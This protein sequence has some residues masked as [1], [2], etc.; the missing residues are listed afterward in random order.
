MKPLG[1]HGALIPP[2]R[3]SLPHR[4]CWVVRG[5]STA[6][7]GGRAGGAD[8]GPSDDMNLPLRDSLHFVPVGPR[9]AHYGTARV[10]ACMGGA[11]ARGAGVLKPTLLPSGCQTT[12]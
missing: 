12:L 4:P 8:M 7:D 3:H 9:P 6:L 5:V 10:G 2:S 11:G 1:T